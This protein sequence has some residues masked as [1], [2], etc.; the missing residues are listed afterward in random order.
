LRYYAYRA[1][2]DPAT[3]PTVRTCLQK[4]VERFPTYSTAWALLSQIY[5]DEMRFGYPADPSSSQTPID[6]ALAA[7]RRAMEL[8]PQNV[9]GL[10][11]EMFALYFKRDVASALK[12]GAQALAI[13]PNDTELMGEYGYRLALSGDW[14]RG[15]PLVAEARLRN[16]G[17]FAYYESALALCEYI[18]G[19]KKAAEMWIRK[20]P[21]PENAF[22]HLIS[23]AIFAE[24]GSSLDATS[25]RDWLMQ[26]APALVKN[27]RSEIG[28]RV[29]REQDVQRLVGSLKKA[30]LPILD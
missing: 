19:D 8:D 5:I 1:N 11:A 27:L 14:D 7:A 10:Q 6:R 23:A 22:Y 2:L 25:E 24:S 20:T 18:R 15:C 29:S 26:N 16:P 17:P 9:R 4:A 28:L 3:H 12:V 21:A 13:N 30:G